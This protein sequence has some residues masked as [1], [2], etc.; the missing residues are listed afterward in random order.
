M[1]FFFF[2][3]F[4]AVVWCLIIQRCLFADVPPASPTRFLA[5]AVV[6]AAEKKVTSKLLEPSARSEKMYKVDDHVAVAVA[7]ITA[8]ANILINYARRAAQVP[9]SFWVPM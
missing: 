8:D 9:T 3:F 1:H 5:G 4:F 6:L 2:F 7:G